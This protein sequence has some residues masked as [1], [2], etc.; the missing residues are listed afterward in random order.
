MISSSSLRFAAYF[1]TMARLFLSRLTTEVFAIKFFSVPGQLR[2][3]SEWELERRKQRLRFGVVR[4]S[5][6]NCDVHPADRVDLVVLDLGEDDQLLHA[7]VVVPPAVE[8]AAGHAAEV[9]DAR[10]GDVDEAVEEFVHPA[11]AQRDL[12]ADRIAG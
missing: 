3:V 8:R 6:G 5:G 2:S 11:P 10:H 4:G 12:A 7:E 1:L 9:A